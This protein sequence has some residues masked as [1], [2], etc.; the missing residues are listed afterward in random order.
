MVWLLKWYRPFVHGSR[1]DQDL[2][3]TI[4]TKNIWIRT[5]FTS[6]TLLSCWEGLILVASVL[7]PE[8]FNYKLVIH[9]TFF[10]ILFKLNLSKLTSKST[11]ISQN[12]VHFQDFESLKSEFIWISSCRDCKTLFSQDLTSQDCWWSKDLV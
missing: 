6:T 7:A 5:L 9:Q 12:C 10:K 4:V 11:Y 1:R 8:L 2:P 3:P